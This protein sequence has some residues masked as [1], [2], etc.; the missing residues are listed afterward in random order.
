MVH[1][2]WGNPLSSLTADSGCVVPVPAVSPG[3][4]M[5]TPKILNRKYRGYY[6]NNAHFFRNRIGTNGN[7]F[8]LHLQ[9]NRTGWQWQVSVTLSWYFPFLIWIILWKATWNTS[10]GTPWIEE[11]LNW[12]LLPVKP[13]VTEPKFL[14]A[15]L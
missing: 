3:I 14:R 13:E 2:R 4:F 8:L 10:T 9:S 6:E 11:H 15:Q 1:A 5:F 12:H 7:S